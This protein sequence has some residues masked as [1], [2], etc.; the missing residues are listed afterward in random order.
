MREDRKQYVGLL[1]NDPKEI[2]E[3]GAQI[4]AFPT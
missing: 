3:E 2:L 1:T 4:V